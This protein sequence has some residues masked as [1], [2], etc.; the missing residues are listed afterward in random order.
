M[1][2][3]GFA[4]STAID[5]HDRMRTELDDIDNANPDDFA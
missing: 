5:D 2:Y 4:L 1:R 3:L